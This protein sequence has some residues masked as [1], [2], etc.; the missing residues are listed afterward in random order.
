MKK[1]YFFLLLGL[2]ACGG[3]GTGEGNDDLVIVLP[4]GGTTDDFDSVIISEVD[5]ENEVVEIFNPTS[6]TVDLSTYWIC[7]SNGGGYLRLDDA[8][9]VVSGNSGSLSLEENALVTLDFSASTV[10]DRIDNANGAD[11]GLYNTNDFVSSS[12]IVDY[13]KF[14]TSPAFGR[15]DIA[16]T[17]S[18]WVSNEIVDVSRISSGTTLTR[19]S[20]TV[21]ENGW[22][23]ETASLGSFETE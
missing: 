22:S 5:I 13:V 1:L 15:E 3:T 21:G 12:A 6:E 17:A 20:S 8:D 10:S 4:G 11:I 19:V 14:G 9:I 2:F 23:I 16:I 7:I 18:L